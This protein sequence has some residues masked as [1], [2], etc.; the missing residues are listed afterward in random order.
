MTDMEVRPL[1]E[2]FPPNLALIVALLIFACAGVHIY[3][4]KMRMRGAG[5]IYRSSEPKRFRDKLILECAIAALLVVYWIFEI[6]K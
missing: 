5:P 3:T 6:S 1:K 4:G 2:S